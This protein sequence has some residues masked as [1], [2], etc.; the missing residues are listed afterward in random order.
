MSKL[1]NCVTVLKGSVKMDILF[2]RHAESESFHFGVMDLKRRLTASG[3]K[4]FQKN[5]PELIDKLESKNTQNIELWSSPAYRALETTEI[6]SKSLRQKTKSVYDFIYHGSFEA[7]QAEVKNVEVDKTIIIVGHEP[8]LG[9][10][11]HHITGEQLTVKNG[12]IINIHIENESMF[13]GKIEW[14]ITPSHKLLCS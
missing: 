10:W 3:K 5:L 4:N 7:L 14:E 6:I 9:D 2:V 11:I 12:H 13:K 8:I 1:K